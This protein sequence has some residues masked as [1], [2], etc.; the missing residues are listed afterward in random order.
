ME[1]EAFYKKGQK[2]PEYQDFLECG[3]L[4]LKE[5]EFLIGRSNSDVVVL[6]DGMGGLRDG[7]IASKFV[8]KEF[9]KLSMEAGETS[10]DEIRSN[11]LATHEALIN[12]SKTRYGFTCMGST[13][14]AVLPSK[15]YIWIAN[16]G[17]TRAYL[18]NETDIKQVSVDDYSDPQETS[19]LTQCIGGKGGGIL[20]PHITKIEK[21]PGLKIVLCTDGLYR[22]IA[23]PKVVDYNSSEDVSKITNDDDATY[24]KLIF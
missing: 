24:L 21:T 4:V 14:C 15:S 7:D 16:V 2:R 5:N 22:A 20:R 6:C 12:F 3:N 13:L 19:V 9:A 18:V 1:F 23:I 10:E 17:D 8:A 11:V